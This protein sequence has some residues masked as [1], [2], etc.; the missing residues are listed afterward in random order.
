MEKWVRSGQWLEYVVDAAEAG[1]PLGEVLTGRLGLSARLVKE[2]AAA[3][4]LRLGRVPARPEAAVAAGE[5]IGLQALAPEPYGVPPE[6]VPFGVLYEDDHLLVA[7]KPAGV[8]V[9]PPDAATGGTL[10]HGVAYHYLLNGLEARVRHIHRLDTDTTGAVLFAK[11][12]LAHVLL[13]AALAERRIKREYAAVVAGC[14]QPAQGALRWP[15]GRDRHRAGRFR[16]HPGG[17]PAVTHYRVLEPYAGAALV[18]LT[19]ETGRTHQIR[20][21]MAHAG[22]PL[23]GDALYGGPMQGIARQALHAGTLALAH[24]FTGEA[25]R[26]AAPWPADFAALVASLRTGG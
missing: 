19:L 7:D 2:F 12:A 6:P 23:L 15:L 18:A 8:L 17:V 10:A 22:H 13:D 1:R 26:I 20:V 9:H 3:G 4:G 11:H 24:P 21:H 16:V 5:R 25:L 14:P